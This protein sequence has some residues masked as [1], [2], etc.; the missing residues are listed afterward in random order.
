[1]KQH[2]SIL[3]VVVIA[4]LERARTGAAASAAAAAASL[5]HRGGGAG[6]SGGANWYLRAPDGSSQ[7]PYGL[8]QLEQWSGAGYVPLGETSWSQSTCATVAQLSNICLEIELYKRVP[9]YHVLQILYQ[10]NVRVCPI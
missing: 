6:S 3:A 9:R 7:G 1:M 8:D 5:G 10:Q 2:A 4:L